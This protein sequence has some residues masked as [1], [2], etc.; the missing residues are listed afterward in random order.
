[1]TISE[2]Q[3]YYEQARKIQKMHLF[4]GGAT[5]AVELVEFYSE[6]WIRPFGSS[7]RQFQVRVELGA[8]PQL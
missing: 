2:R 3:K 5:A 7:L 4:A 6:G 1:M 8:V